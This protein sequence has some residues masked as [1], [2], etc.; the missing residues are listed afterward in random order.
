MN[1]KQKLMIIFVLAGAVSVA[2]FKPEQTGSM[3][4]IVSSIAVCVLL[5]SKGK[6]KT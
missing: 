6:E 5:F 3:V 4:G 1:W 2:I